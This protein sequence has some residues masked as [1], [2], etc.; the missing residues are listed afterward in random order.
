MEVSKQVKRNLNTNLELGPD[1]YSEPEVTF[2]GDLK[3]D[4]EPSLASLEGEKLLQTLVSLT[5]LPEGFA[6]QELNQ[7]LQ[8]TGESPENRADMTL[9][10]LRAAL[11]R[12]LELLGPG[13]PELE[14][15]ELSCSDELRE[16]NFKQISEH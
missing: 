8:S 13:D 4:S 10:D 11:V 16:K 3:M 15:S 1:F 14:P 7:I 5:G 2:Q 9:D 12:Y 6:H